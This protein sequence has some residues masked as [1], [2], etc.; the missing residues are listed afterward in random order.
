MR[1]SSRAWVR[2]WVGTC[3]LLPAALTSCND[4]PSE[5]GGPVALVE[6]T[7]AFAAPEIGESVQ[8]RA[9]AKDD[10]GRRAS[11][12]PV[13]WAS[14]NEAVAAVS[15]RG[16]VTGVSPGTAII[17]ATVGE[18]SGAAAITVARCSIVH[19][20][21]IS[22]GDT[23]AGSLDPTDCLLGD[24]T[25]ADGYLI[26]LSEATTVQVDLRA[27]FDTYLVLLQLL[28][29]GNLVLVTLNDDLDPDDPTD[30]DDTIDTNSQV[31]YTLEAGIPYFILAN[32]FAPDIT[33]NYQ[34]TVTEVSALEGRYATHIKPGKA[35]ASTLL[36]TLRR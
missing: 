32:S 6:V 7:P 5:P 10:R 13:V 20:G 21:A 1:G 18:F 23:V 25:Y 15:Q 22:V 3:G 2:L 29:D 36:R 31:V 35:P 9:E 4:T 19:A 8:L 17:T 24:L 11:S 34:L 33:G 28:P 27:S 26:Q 30:P 12:E 14:S 16:L